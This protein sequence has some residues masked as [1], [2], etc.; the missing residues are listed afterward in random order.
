[1]MRGAL[2]RA[3]GVCANEYAPD[4]GCVVSYDHGCG[5]HSEALVVHS[6][7]VS[8]AESAGPDLNEADTDVVAEAVADASDVS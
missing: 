5:A 3:F 4:D 1:M 7:P 6:G 8:S 2:S